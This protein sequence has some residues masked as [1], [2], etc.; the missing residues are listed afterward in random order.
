[1]SCHDTGGAVM[2][3]AESGI[4]GATALHRVV[5][6]GNPNVGKSTLFN[7]LTGARQRTM[8]APGTTVQLEVGRWG[9]GD[10][11]IELID[12]PGTHS[13]LARSPDEQVTADAV[14]GKPVL[15][16]KVLLGRP[17][18]AIV[19]IDST[20]LCRGL[21]LLAQVAEAGVPVVVGLS[22]AK[23]AKSRGAAVAADEL[24]ER[25]G[26]SVM[27][28][29]GRTGEGLKELREAVEESFVSPAIPTG[30]AAHPEAFSDDGTSVDLESWATEHADRHFDWVAELERAMSAASGSG[31]QKLT[32]SDR[33]DKVL[34]NPWLGIPVF[35]A[36]LWAVFQLTTTVAAPLQ[37]WLDGPVRDLFTGWSSSFLGVIGLDGSW[38]EGIINDGVMGG[39]ITVLTFIPPMGIMFIALSLLEDCGYMARAAFVADRAMRAIGLDGRAFLPLIVG[40]G[41]NLPSLAATR[42]LPNAKQRLLTGLVIPF[43]SCAARLPVY[44]LLATV[45]FPDHAGTAV[46]LMYVASVVLIVLGGLLLRHTVM[47]DIKP[48][49][50]V[51]ALPEYQLPRIKPMAVSVYVRLRG[52]VVK[53]GRI[54]II[55]L[56]CMWLLQAIP[57]GGSG[58]GTF[59]D[60]PIEESVYGQVAEAAA[61]VFTPAG[62]GDWHA[63][64]ALITGF[65]AK[66][67]V[68]ASFS[69]AYSV[70]EPEDPDQPGD[71][72]TQLRATFERTSNGHGAAAAAAFMLFVLAYTPC[73]A[74]MAEQRR[75]FGWKPTLGA[76]VFQ[77]VLAYVLAIVT[78]QIGSLL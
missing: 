44:V 47:R 19:V 26:V 57:M 33:V 56:T 13:L 75:L 39:V 23:A 6:V 17:D 60:T 34:L 59:A 52:F 1:M 50:F 25:L 41:C 77:L 40:F 78:F 58:N 54:I 24:A 61:P 8:N 3:P 45:F 51:L 22:M 55:V 14:L 53:A 42:T 4:A 70:S 12:L 20:A 15:S 48:E 5:L 31:G 62:F 68:V 2:E 11:V 67:V 29:D 65:V 76:V 18:T 37:D 16:S 9:R 35:L 72:G 46:F 7:A 43:T 38:V 63:S 32:W 64:S 27:V 74:T 21:Y 28:I 71:L 73:V 36:V 69:Q 66:E 30:L 49:P 10:K